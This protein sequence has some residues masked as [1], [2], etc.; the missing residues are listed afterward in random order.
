[1]LSTSLFVLKNAS[2]KVFCTA[3]AA[4]LCTSDVVNL[5]SRRS[6][7]TEAL[8]WGG[9]AHALK[10]NLSMKMIGKDNSAGATPPA[11]TSATLSTEWARAGS[12]SRIVDSLPDGL[13]YDE[14]I[15]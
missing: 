4:L 15:D 1:M 5:T 12:W 2:W 13:S 6:D 14:A 9:Q 8:T 7:G 10:L 11:G 3:V